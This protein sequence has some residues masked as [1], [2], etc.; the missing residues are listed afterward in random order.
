MQANH[1]RP[2]SSEAHFRSMK[3]LRAAAVSECEALGT[4]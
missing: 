3:L 4:R 2:L 1:R